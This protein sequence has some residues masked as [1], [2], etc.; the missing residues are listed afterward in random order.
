MPVYPGSGE[1]WSRGGGGGLMSAEPSV[2]EVPNKTDFET[3]RSP[4]VLYLR[5]AA[6]FLP[7]STAGRFVPSD[8]SKPAF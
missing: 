5:K 1:S 2:S 8:G 6:S 4:N 3:Q 7:P